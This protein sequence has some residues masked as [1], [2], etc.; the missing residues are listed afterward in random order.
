MPS[1]KVHEYLSKLFFGKPYGKIHRVLDFPSKW[2]GR[3]HRILFHDMFS[4]SLI[5]MGIS[6]DPMAPY[7]AQYHV[8]FDEICS[9]DRDFKIWLEINA[10]YD[11]FIRKLLKQS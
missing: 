5:G 6:D 3:K 7:V 1:R 11:A 10:Q 8:I 4:A 9:E 2:L